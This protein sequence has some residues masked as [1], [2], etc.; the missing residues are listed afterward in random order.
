MACCNAQSGYPTA[1]ELRHIITIER[2]TE[3]ADEYGGHATAWATLH[4]LR[5]KI[6]PLTARELEHAMRMESRSSHRITIRYKSGITAADRV[7]YGGRLMQIRGV[8]DLG[9]RRKWLE[10]SCDEGVSV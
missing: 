7:N 4:T 6:V 3:T 2:L 1:G 10:L 5:A 9:E 8:I